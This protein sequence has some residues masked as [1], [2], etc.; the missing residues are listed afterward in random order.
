MLSMSCLSLRQT[1]VS[2]CVDGFSCPLEDRTVEWVKA[3]SL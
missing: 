2:V 1:L 3:L